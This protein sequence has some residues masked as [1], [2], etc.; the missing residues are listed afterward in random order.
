[1]LE[2]DADIEDYPY[3]A[4]LLSTG[5][6]GGGYAYCGASIINEYWILTAAHC[7]QGESANG[8]AVRVGSD[9]D[10]AQGGVTYDA[11][12]IP[13]YPNYNANTLNNDIAL[14]RVDGP[15]NFNNSTQPVVLMCDQ[16]VALGVQ[17]PGQSSWITGWVK[18][19]RNN[20]PNSTSSC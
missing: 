9:N 20:Q 3:N 15:I 18:H 8:T 6:W 13:L 12:E 16:Q 2:V 1:M 5:G 17:E 7:V 4:A 14:I 11:L 10:Y 19:R